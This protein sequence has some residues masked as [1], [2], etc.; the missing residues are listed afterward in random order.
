MPIQL[1]PDSPVG[2]NRH[3]STTGHALNELLPTG[4]LPFPRLPREQGGAYAVV[5]CYKAVFNSNSHHRSLA[6][7]GC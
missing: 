7:A 1:E 3:A 5:G 4:V 6:A 2:N